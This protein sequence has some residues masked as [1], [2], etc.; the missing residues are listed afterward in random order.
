VLIDVPLPRK[1]ALPTRLPACA[2]SPVEPGARS[3][4][5]DTPGAA[6]FGFE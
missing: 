5:T 4:I 2:L 3:E 1:Y 6:M